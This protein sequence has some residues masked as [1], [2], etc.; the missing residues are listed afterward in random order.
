MSAG[1]AVYPGGSNTYVKNHAATGNLVIS[2][3]RN[4]KDFPFARYD[5]YKPVK[6]DSGY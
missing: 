4:P 3:S 6:K 1:T 2:F 5:Q